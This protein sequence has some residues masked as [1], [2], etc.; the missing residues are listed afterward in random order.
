MSPSMTPARRR[1]AANNGI[2]VVVSAVMIFPVYWMLATAFKQR[3][4]ILSAVPQF[5]PWPISLENFRRALGKPHFWVFVGNSL[6][7]TLS[8]VVLS[9]V[10]ALFAAIAIARFRF[11]GRRALM[12]VLVL[13]QMV[14]MSAMVIPV[15]LMLRSINALDYLPGLV[16]TYMTFVLP[17]TIWTLRGFV[18]GVPVELEEAALVDGCGRLQMYVRVL[19]PLLMPGIVAT[20]IF[21]FVNA[22][23]DYLFAYVIMKSQA[24]YTL[25][26]WLVSFKTAESVDYGAMIAASTI[27]SI[28]VLVFFLLVQRRLVGGMTSGAVKG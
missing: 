24:N 18:E 8:S 15:Y 21:A 16:L 13:V 7:V 4:H 26:V 3:G 1:R 17:F 12:A 6:T 20:S 9:L 19:L 25:P 10:I 23:D 14:P 5:F 11:H 22:W 27:F 2:A 28:P